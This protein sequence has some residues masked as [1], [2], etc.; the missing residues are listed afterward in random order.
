MQPALAAL[1]ACETGSSPRSHPGTT[2]F[3][4]NFPPPIKRRLAQPAPA[5]AVPAGAAT[6]RAWRLNRLPSLSTL[7]QPDQ[8]RR[9]RLNWQK[10]RHSSVEMLSP[11]STGGAAALRLGTG[12][13]AVW[14][15]QPFCNRQNHGCDIPLPSSFGD[16]PTK[17]P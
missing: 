11:G 3:K 10:R 1:W 2:P 12:S 6:L 13:S 5:H 17:T 4:L 9:Q 14:G 15:S 7:C 16:R 8:P